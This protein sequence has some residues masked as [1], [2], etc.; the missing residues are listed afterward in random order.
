MPKVE[1]DGDVKEYL[2]ARKVRRE[3]ALSHRG[4]LGETAI[5]NTKHGLRSSYLMVLI[6]ACTSSTMNA[7][8]RH[9]GLAATAFL[10]NTVIQGERSICLFLF[11]IMKAIGTPLRYLS[12]TII[13][14]KGNCNHRKKYITKLCSGP[15]IHCSI[16]RSA[17]AWEAYHDT[18]ELLTLFPTVIDR[19]R[20]RIREWRGENRNRTEVDN[21]TF[22]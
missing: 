1:E 21:Q 6:L 10:F 16:A 3:L 19:D 2:A 9:S 7:L 12:N 8:G 17:I 5:D 18:R 11:V 14:S 15:C 20:K 4:R 13:V 22:P